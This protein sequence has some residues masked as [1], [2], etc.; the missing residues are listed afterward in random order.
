MKC[1]IGERHTF[2]A[3]FSRYGTKP[4]GKKRDKRLPTICLQDIKDESGNFVAVRVWVGSTKD[5]RSLALKPGQRISFDATVDTYVKGYKGKASKSRNC[6]RAKVGGHDQ[7][8]PHK[9]DEDTNGH[10]KFERYENVDE[11]ARGRR[12]ILGVLRKSEHPKS[13][14]ERRDKYRVGLEPFCSEFDGDAELVTAVPQHIRGYKTT[15]TRHRKPHNAKG[16]VAYRL[17]RVKSP[18]IIPTPP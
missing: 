6:S 13:A 15:P 12:A 3:T 11:Y 2:S 14:M 8:E 18:R 10:R 16:T 9:S 4:G 5:M 1:L 17:S 7:P